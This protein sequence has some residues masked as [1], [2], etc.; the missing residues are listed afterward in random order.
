MHQHS[1]DLT[2]ADFKRDPFPTLRVMSQLSPIVRTKMPFLGNVWVTTTYA[3]TSEVLRHKETF[4]TNP[5]NAGLRGMAGFRW[6]MPTTLRAITSNM[7][8]KDEP[9]H[10]RLRKI[11]ET[12]FLGQS[13]QSMQTNISQIATTQLNTLERQAKET[14]GQVDLIKYFARP[15][16]LAVICELLGLPEED[17]HRILRW[18]VRFTNIKNSLDLVRA[19]PAIWK[20]S[21]YFRKQFE[22]CKNHTSEGMISDLVRTEQYGNELNEEELLATV[23]LLL[24]AG[25]ETTVHLIAAGTLALLRHPTQKKQ[26]VQDWSRTGTAIDE[27]LRYNC[28]VQ[29]TEPRYVA[30]DMDF[31]GNHLRRGDTVMPFLAAANADP[32]QFEH[33]ELFDLNRRPNQ[34]LAFG[35]GIHTCLG[36][37]LAKAEA[38][39]ALQQIFTRFPDI[40]LAVPVTNIAWGE[41]VGTRSILG[42]PIRIRPAG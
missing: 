21:R 38:S 9:D 13:I 11:V 8:G 19:F 35:S 22:H 7:L 18:G 4:V 41:G 2:S 24:L 31:H 27:M 15:F 23:F 40:E 34:H 17:R 36:L 6:W 20:I 28:T 42:L 3:S 37:R 5:R 14:N 32:M 33:P 10:R 29:T 12:A 25:H 16:P 26:L 39:T 1:F 30:N